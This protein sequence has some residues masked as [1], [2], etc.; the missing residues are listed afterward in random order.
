MYAM[1]H[2]KALIVLAI[3]LMCVGTGPGRSR[4]EDP[5]GAARPALAPRHV[6][7]LGE[8][9]LIGGV[10]FSKDGSTLFCQAGTNKEDHTTKDCRI[11][12]I[13][14][15]RGRVDRTLWAEHGQTLDPRAL[16][17]DGNE[18]IAKYRYEPEVAII[19]TTRGGVVRTINYADDTDSQL[20]D[21]PALIGFSSDRRTA[22]VRRLVGPEQ[23]SEVTGLSLDNGERTVHI[24]FRSVPEGC[25][26]SILRITPGTETMLLEHRYAASWGDPMNV[27]L[28]DITPP[29]DDTRVLSI[30]QGMSS[31]FTFGNAGQMMVI[32]SRRPEGICVW[33]IKTDK[34]SLFLP[35]PDGRRL[36]ATP[37]CSS[38]CD[39][40][41]VRAWRRPEQGAAIYNVIV[42]SVSKGAWF[43]E[44]GYPEGVIA[45]QPHRLVA[46]PDGMTLATACMREGPTQEVTGCKLLL[47]D[48]SVLEGTGA[49]ACKPT[50]VHKVRKE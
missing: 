3:V 47:W 24:N 16:T 17:P 33:D 14:A 4:G 9:T 48:L 18:L 15:R 42:A 44:L 10:K 35:A 11:L 43:A 12:A 37:V 7:D 20:L 19:S 36:V 21:P 41:F 1:N 39:R 34:Q 38:K 40:V 27:L 2:L 26:R 23:H 31:S 28:H 5:L 46:S 30:P 29:L 32:R 50:D 22:F 25:M 6:I 49:D 13:D 45:C 8:H